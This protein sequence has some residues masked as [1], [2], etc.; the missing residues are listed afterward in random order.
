[1]PVLADML[2]YQKSPVDWEVGFQPKD[3]FSEKGGGVYMY[4]F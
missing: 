2:F 4:I 3:W 1:M